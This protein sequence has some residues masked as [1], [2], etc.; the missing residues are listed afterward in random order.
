MR[1][2]IEKI[3]LWFDD[4]IVRSLEFKNNKIN[5][6]TGE[7]SKG[8]SSV[9]EII[10]YCFFAS[11]N[12]IAQDNGY[13]NRVKWYGIKFTIND[14]TFT[15]IRHAKNNKEYYFSSSDEIPKIPYVNAK[16]DN[17]KNA[18]SLEFSINDNVIFP[19]GGDFIKK[20]S[21]ISPRYFMLF[22]T[23]RRDTLSSD[24]VL[25]DKQ[26]ILKQQEA[27]TRIFD[28]ALGVTTVDNLIKKELLSEKEKQLYFLKVKQKKL[29]SGTGLFTEEIEI[30][31][32][33]AKTYNLVD[34]DLSLNDSIN[35]IKS[36][37]FNS[38]D[39]VFENNHIK[40][41]LLEEHKFL[42]KLQLSKYTEYVKQ[43]ETYKKL[44]KNELDSLAPV[45]FLRNKHN[46]LLD[47]S[48]LS[49]IF[50]GLEKELI[51]IRS[52][53]HQ[54]KLPAVIDLQS[55]ISRLSNDLLQIESK[56]NLII[57]D[58][59][60][61]ASSI[62]KEQL[63]FIGEAKAK[64]EFYEKNDSKETY[65]DEI[66]ELGNQIELLKNEVKSI[67]RSDVLDTLSE[68][69]QEI[70][71]SV[72]FE[73]SGYSGYKPIYDY[74]R[75]LVNLKRIDEKVGM[76][77]I[78]S[79]DT[80]MNIGSSSNHL[81]LHLAFFSAIHRLFIKQKTPYI[82]TFLILDQPDSPYYDSTSQNS[83]EKTTFLKAL[84]ILDNHIDTFNNNLKRDFQIIVLEHISWSDIE[85]AKFSNYHLVEEWFGDNTGLV[86]EKYSIGNNNGK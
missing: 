58:D 73:L 48:G 32:N 66:S 50:D 74:K 72:Q 83:S 78:D 41:E 30:L 49:V 69:M 33:K 55:E 53:V 86:P 75:K 84:K 42:I 54:K 63:L 20:N 70:F 23:Q 38:D 25:F 22:N 57:F 81:F 71:K 39:M 60:V 85:K 16:E 80:I 46:E 13:L 76:D 24:Q 28:I 51:S 67:D 52:I 40:L 59:K 10:D 34:T 18:I 82:P 1:F 26:T 35:A 43:Y 31:C 14:K 77:S 9:I 4:N 79:I 37:I 15:I 45:D 61:T 3:I 12:P 2:F 5:V 64:F 17:I 8:K 65:D 27:L 44:L 36:L 62:R 19:F 11:S 29:N 47:L 56:I 21:K 7:Q 68:Y 6:I